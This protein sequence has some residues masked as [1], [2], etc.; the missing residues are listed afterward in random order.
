M[1]RKGKRRTAKR[2]PRLRRLTRKRRRKR[3]NQKDQG[4]TDFRGGA[5]QDEAHLDS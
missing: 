5:Q 1:K 4:D 2:R 3:R